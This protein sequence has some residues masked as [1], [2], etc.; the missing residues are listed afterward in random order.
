MYLIYSYC[1]CYGYFNS[2]LLSLCLSPS[3][4]LLSGFVN[5]EP[6]LFYTRF[7]LALSQEYCFKMY[8]RKDTKFIFRRGFVSVL[9]TAAYMTYIYILLI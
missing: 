7:T 6:A 1:C 5:F 9:T 4:C 2:S 8:T 3:V